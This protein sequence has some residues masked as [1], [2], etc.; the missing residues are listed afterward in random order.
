MPQYN[1]SYK[2]G[3]ERHVKRLEGSR[4]HANRTWEQYLDRL[5]AKNPAWGR[6][7]IG[8]HRGGEFVPAFVSPRVRREVREQGIPV[9]A[10]WSTGDKATFVYLV[11]KN[12][13]SR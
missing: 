6:A 13:G 12:T 4:A 8:K 5:D 2:L 10:S 9:A 11:E 3:L 1:L 7:R